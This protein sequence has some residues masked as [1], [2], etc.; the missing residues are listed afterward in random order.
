MIISS[1]I[2]NYN[3]KIGCV[4]EKKDHLADFCEITELELKKYIDKLV[5]KGLSIII[6]SKEGNIHYFLG[7]KFRSITNKY[8][9][10]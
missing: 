8:N 5:E 6:E 2:T 7:A 4:F 3:T 10:L 1:I 9:N